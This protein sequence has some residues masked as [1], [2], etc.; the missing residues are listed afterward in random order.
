MYFEK[1]N[2]AS[3]RKFH[4]SLEEMKNPSKWICNYIYSLLLL[5]FAIF[6]TFNNRKGKKSHCN[7]A[8]FIRNLWK[9]RGIVHKMNDILHCGCMY[10]K[11]LFIRMYH[12]GQLISKFPFGVIVLAKIP[13]K[14]FL[15]ISALSYP[16]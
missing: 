7:N 14:F 5:A 2:F 9:T 16:R 4:F 3:S 11:I 15:R 13:M 1:V 6:C 12:K 10:V 8:K